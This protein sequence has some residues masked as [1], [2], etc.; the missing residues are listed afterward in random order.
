MESLHRRP[1]ILGSPLLQQV[2]AG[3]AEAD[4]LLHLLIRG[5]EALQRLVHSH[6][7]I[8]MNQYLFNS[9]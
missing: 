6:G 9:Q 2:L 1:G 7:L 5:D 4:L 3:R 8:K